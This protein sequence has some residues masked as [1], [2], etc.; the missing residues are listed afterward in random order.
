MKK[1][2]L[3]GVIASI[4]SLNA[5]G[6]SATVTSKD[7]VDTQDALKQNKIPAAWVNY[8]ENGGG[9]SVVTYTDAA[10][11]LGERGICNDPDEDDCDGGDLVT[12]ERLNNV[13]ST[14]TVTYKTCI[15]WVANAAH[16]DA[17]CILWNLGDKSVFGYQCSTSQE[18]I[19]WG[20]Q[21]NCQYGA[22][23]EEYHCECTER[24]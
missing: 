18:C 9:E 20:T 6:V 2:I 11:V 12:S 15:E 23:C 7:Y 10:G 3:F 22:S 16:T 24:E 13:L 17:N 21:H 19:D 5:Y 1:Y 14:T 4:L 8:D